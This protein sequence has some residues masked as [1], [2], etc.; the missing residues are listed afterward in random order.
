MSY[1][2]RFLSGDRIYPRTDLKILE[3]N[4]A[5]DFNV[6][7]HFVK[8]LKNENN[9]EYDYAGFIILNHTVIIHADHLLL[10]AN[11]YFNLYT[12]METCV[13]EHILRYVL[14]RVKTCHGFNTV[15]ANPH[16]LVVEYIIEN[17]ITHTDSSHILANPHDDVVDLIMKNVE[18]IE[19]LLKTY[20][21][22]QVFSNT[23]SRMIELCYQER[24]GDRLVTNTTF[25]S[26]LAPSA[27]QIKLDYFRQHN[28][29]FYYEYIGFLTTS[30]VPELLKIVIEAV[31]DCVHPSEHIISNLF[32]NPF[33]IAVEYCFER[34]KG[35][36]DDDLCKKYHSWFSSNSNDRVVDYFLSHVELIDTT[37]FL[38]NTNPRA[39]EYNIN[40]METTTLTDDEIRHLIQ[41]P[42]VG[43]LPYIF[44]RNDIVDRLNDLSRF[45]MCCC[46]ANVHVEIN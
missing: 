35:I 42:N 10:E 16:P 15:F 2:V 13:N 36:V 28:L 46:D 39:V 33:D 23:N 5:A 18:P 7:P 14:D 27:E 44:S 3:H 29:L 43:L 45:R 4:I 21:A 30:Q 20:K 6:S 40:R 9:D 26:N 34:L 17:Q 19:A 38:T 12:C 22:N 37:E 32:A 1:V 41:H 25:L 11:S 8:L 31:K 24:G